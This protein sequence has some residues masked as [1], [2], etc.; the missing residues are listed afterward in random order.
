MVNKLNDSL[1]KQALSCT[2]AVYEGRI[3]SLEDA[4]ARPKIL[5]V[6]AAGTIIDQKYEIIGLI[7]EGGMGAVYR[8]NHLL[9]KKEMA[10]KTF[11]SHGLSQSAWPRF[12]REAQAIAKLKHKNI[13]GVFDFGIA[14][15][16]IP[17][18]TMERLS[19]ESLASRLA[20]RGPLEPVEAL[21]IFV[22]AAEAMAHAT[23][24]ANCAP[25]HQ[26][27]KYLFA[28]TTERPWHR[29][30]KICR[31][32]YCQVGPGQLVWRG[33]IQYPRRHHFWY[34]TLYES[35]AIAG[36]GG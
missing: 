4:D 25:R 26:T 15:E 24:A 30:G 21:N 23:S 8:V 18:Y 12:Q 17:Y 35:G 10:L 32:W 29:R 5:E 9:L 28:E 14:Q 19:G 16:Q 3:E 20:A 34:S 6:L 11:R 2:F 22:M 13:I 36:C 1:E 7:G 27:S 33:S 31:L